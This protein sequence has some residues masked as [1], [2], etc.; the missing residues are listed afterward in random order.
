M[1]ILSEN[2][3]NEV[4]HQGYNDKKEKE[5]KIKMDNF[6]KKLEEKQ[7]E[8]IMKETKKFFNEQKKKLL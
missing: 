1:L 7:Q 4:G 6:R 3:Y 2:I 5:K 8:K